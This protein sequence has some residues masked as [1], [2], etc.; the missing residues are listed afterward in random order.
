[1][2]Q[3][4]DIKTFNIGL[5]KDVDPRF[6]QQGEYSEASNIMITNSSEGKVGSVTNLEH[7]SIVSND[8]WYT[9]NGDEKVIGLFKDTKNNSIYSFIADPT[10]DYHRLVKFDIENN[11]HELIFTSEELPWSA[12]T[13]I[14]SFDIVDGIVFWTDG[15]SEPM[16]FN[17]NIDYLTRLGAVEWDVATTYSAGDR[18]QYNNIVYYTT[19]TN[20]GNTPPT[21]FTT[22]SN[23]I[24]DNQT[25][26]TE[27]YFTI[28]KVVPL[29]RPNVEITSATNFKGNNITGRFFQFKYRFVF[30]GNERSTFS[31]VSDLAYTTDDYIDPEG[32]SDYNNAISIRVDSAGANYL[33]DKVELVAREGNNGTWKFITDLDASSLISDGFIDYTFFNNG[34]YSPIALDES[35]QIYDDVPKK[36]GTQSYISNRLVFGNCTTG[37]DKDI[38]LDLSIEPVYG[39][40][41]GVTANSYD[42]STSINGNPA[43]NESPLETE[44][45]LQQL[46][47][48]I[49]YVAAAGDIIKVV[50]VST[51]TDQL[52]IGDGYVVVKSGWSTAE[53]FA[54]LD[55]MKFN[56]NTGKSVLNY[57]GSFTDIIYVKGSGSST[58]GW[59]QVQVYYENDHY[60]IEIS[61]QQHTACLKSNAWYN[62][63]FQY[64]DQFGRTNGVI[65]D[66]AYKFYIS[67]VGDRYISDYSV[68][69]P[70]TKK[71]SAGDTDGAGA[72]SALITIGHTPPSWAAYYSICYSRSKT[73]SISEWMKVHSAAADP[74]TGAIALS[75][76]SYDDFQD[77]NEQASS[78]TYDFAK[79]DR[80]R[81]ITH[82]VSGASA[83][84]DDWADGIYDYEIISQDTSSGLVL[85]AYVDTTDITIAEMTDALVEVYRPGR[86]IDEDESIFYESNIVHPINIGGGHETNY[87]SQDLTG[88]GGESSGVF[89]L[90]YASSPTARY[91]YMTAGGSFGFPKTAEQ[92][93]AYALL[94]LSNVVLDEST[95]PLWAGGTS[96]VAGVDTVQYNGSTYLCALNHT[97]DGTN[98][99]PN[100]TYWTF[101]KKYDGTYSMDYVEV[102]N[103]S[104]F[105]IRITPDTGGT[106]TDTDLSLSADATYET[107]D[108]CM[109]LFA[110]GDA[111]FRTRKLENSSSVV[112]TVNVE[113][114]QVS[115]FKESYQAF[116]GRP[117][118]II[119]QQEEQRIATLM[120][121]ERYIPNTSINNINR[122]FPDVNFEEYNKTFGSIVHLHNEGDSL[123][124]LQEDKISKVMVDRAVTYDAQGQANYLG[125]QSVVLSP[126]ISYA[127][128]YGIRDHRNFVSIGN[129]RYI[130]DLERGVIL[131][132]SIDGIEE[133]SRYGM[134]GYYSSQS[135]EAIKNSNIV[136]V[137][138]Y[139][140]LYDVYMPNFK[141]SGDMYA[142]SEENNRWISNITLFD[143]E[144]AVYVN[145]RTFFA[146]SSGEVYEMNLSGNRNSISDGVTET[147]VN[148]VIRFSSNIEPS[149]LKN[150]FALELD[151]TF[152]LSVDMSTDGINGVSD[153]RTT[154]LSS[155]FTQREQ[156][157]HSAIFR[158]ENTP[159]VTDPLLN[160]DTIKGR[161]A[162]VTLSLT[163]DD[164]LDDW[165]MRSVGVIIS[166]G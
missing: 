25:L 100:A 94:T 78:F 36:A 55:A 115:D 9:V 135:K 30:A 113:S 15:D 33:V 164:R 50:G 110:D 26:L 128:E 22:N 81:F 82:G 40:N 29:R 48:D 65:Y 109:A 13:I 42:T 63:G 157:F 156:V 145:N 18:I 146:N 7:V 34:V 116:I 8:T 69:P 98:Q 112:E 147:T 114:Y 21:G 68:N 23:W 16:M 106:W 150:Y 12:T 85:K 99:P 162:L 155:D 28:A 71:V 161:H 160:G 120:Y 107:N 52:P 103:G 62:V 3:I 88:T 101:Q 137:G 89:K 148:S 47:N 75:M 144:H 45:D 123:T 96:Y 58:S 24:L 44:A 39:T 57:N 111:Y 19:G 153:Q 51:T 121:S 5:N 139:D 140:P 149:V 61:T 129:R 132:L 35:E 87:V 60:E 95:Y 134:K 38:T 73:S 2:A 127:G 91:L 49:G 67:S 86:D 152:P 32:S 151:S 131:R 122:V 142:F 41:V 97:S 105:L 119:D 108:K 20:L 159:N 14:K 92:D 104:F 136:V 27:D 125:T 10:D 64:H 126:S 165:R 138:L 93:G 53:I 154:L 143:P 66:E 76:V 124:M 72:A 1:M 46:F 4:K 59:T 11:T 130:A 90:D 158:D 102:I 70:V 77:R 31:S 133:I 118:A 166:Q 79:G 141:Q 43:R 74:T 83:G 56:T 17:T 163:G 54:A 37:Y 84:I 6:L 117:T 80:V